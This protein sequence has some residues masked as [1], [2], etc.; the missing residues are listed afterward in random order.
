M[1]NIQ[2]GSVQKVGTLSKEA[3]TFFEIVQN[4]PSL[5]TTG[6]LSITLLKILSSAPGSE[7]HVFLSET[8]EVVGGILL[9]DISAL[10]IRSGN[11]SDKNRREAFTRI[12]NEGYKYASHLVVKES[13]R[14]KG[15]V[16]LIWDIHQKFY[17]VLLNKIHEEKIIQHGGE[18]IVDR[19]GEPLHGISN[20]N[21]LYLKVD[22]TDQ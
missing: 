1:N 2:N 3:K 14:G 20:P 12:H 8:K 21:A 18:V 17:L 9:S 22:N 19:N 15:Y 16:D 7:I 11:L 6:F 4:T 13:E 5:N 10:R